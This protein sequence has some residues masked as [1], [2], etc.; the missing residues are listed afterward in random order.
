[1]SPCNIESS[2]WNLKGG[3]RC[4]ASGTRARPDSLVSIS[5][6]KHESAARTRLFV[7]AF[8][9]LVLLAV[10]SGCAAYHDQFSNV[11]QSRRDALAMRIETGE[12]DRL[13]DAAS[14]GNL[15]ARNKLV[16]LLVELIDNNYDGIRKGL[17]GKTSWA[18]FAASTTVLG[19]NAV[20]TVTGGEE[21][22]AILHAAS[23]AIEGTSAAF[24]KSVLQNQSIPAI[25]AG[26]ESNRAE[27]LLVITGGLTKDIVTYSIGAAV[28]DVAEY[29]K[30]GTFVGAISDMQ[31]KAAVNQDK[32]EK[33]TRIIKGIPTIDELLKKGG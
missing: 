1:M 25:L 3:Q 32:A 10:E 6:V 30:A 22:K 14:A 23:G 28:H 13:Y 29:Y 17:Y 12:Y 26:M 15:A 5:V 16:W 2:T 7:K 11:L 4:C 31:K 19:L 24:S 21:L 33:A 18:D 8:L 20:G 9:L 27:K